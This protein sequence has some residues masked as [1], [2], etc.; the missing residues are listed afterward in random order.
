MNFQKLAAYPALPTNR[1]AVVAPQQDHLRVS[2]KA[3]V[4]LIPYGFPFTID[5][6]GEVILMVH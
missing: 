3:G 4:W 5:E 2:T 6:K 1:T